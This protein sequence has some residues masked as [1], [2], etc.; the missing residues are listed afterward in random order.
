MAVPRLAPAAFP[1]PRA[2]LVRQAPR[3]PLSPFFW[4]QGLDPPSVVRAALGSVSAG[5]ACNVLGPVFG[6]LGACE[7]VFYRDATA[8]ADQFMSQVRSF[9]ECVS[10]WPPPQKKNEDEE[11]V[12]RGGRGNGRRRMI[13]REEDDDHDTNQP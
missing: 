6:S 13:I 8:C 2:P 11:Y 10:I 12:E 3:R 9:I 4:E 7:A 5:H 1:T